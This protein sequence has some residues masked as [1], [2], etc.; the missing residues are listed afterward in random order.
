MMLLTSSLGVRKL[1]SHSEHRPQLRRARRMVFTTISVVCSTFLLLWISGNKLYVY[2]KSFL[3]WR[4]GK[5]IG[6]PPDYSKIYAWEDALPQHNLDLPW[7]EGR[8]GRYVKF[9]N[10]ITRLGWNNVLNEV[11]MNTFLAHES[12]RAY[13]FQDYHWKP[14]YH[15]W[16]IPPVTISRRR[17]YPRTPLNAL[18][19]GPSAGGPWE[20]HDPAPRSVSERYWEIVCPVHERK[21]IH[22]RDVK[23]FIPKPSPESIAKSPYREAGGPI[24]RNQQENWDSPWG[25][26]IFEYWKELLSN[27]KERCI[28]IIPTP[29]DEDP[30][31]QTFDVRMFAT[32]KGLPLWEPFS[33]S[34]ASRLLSASPLVRSGA[35]RNLYLF[36][37]R[38]RDGSSQVQLDHSNNT[39]DPLASTLAIHFRL[40][41]YADACINLLGAYNLTFYSWN[42]LPTFSQ[43]MFIPPPGGIPK[44]NNPGELEYGRNTEDNIAIYLK[45]C[46]PSPEAIANK[47]KE[48]KDSWA[49]VNKNQSLH[50]LYI[51]T[52]SSPSQL[53]PLRDA[54]EQQGWSNIVT[55]RDLELDEF[56]TDVSGAVDS[57][58]ARRAAGFIGNGWS[59]FTS[60]IV[61]QRLVS[62]HDPRTIRFW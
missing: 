10:E 28:E 35:D 14:D 22:T 21:I 36:Q 45:R 51:L 13:V 59:S 18:I 23:P 60:N 39:R 25:D 55:S 46:L 52:N 27:S 12:N 40:G 5:I 9:S 2:P 24:G 37:S 19:S 38:A 3:F 34:A 4:G 31:P 44:A 49:H 33:K 50:T 57:E 17:R 61:H 20:P 7:P 15:N 54:F 8:T 48:V 11:L 62:G 42:L 58:I 32:Y 47:V 30:Y 41:D 26:V 16:L 6:S 43:D 53:K 56:Q 1:L 29:L